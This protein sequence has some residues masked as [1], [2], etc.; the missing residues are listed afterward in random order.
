MFVMIHPET[1]ILF[2]KGIRTFED[3]FMD[4]MTGRRQAAYRN[5]SIPLN[6]YAIPKKSSREGELFLGADDGTAASRLSKWF[7]SPQSVR[8]S[9]K[10]APA[11]GSFF[12]SR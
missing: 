6:L 3:A 2:Y 10:K 7:D 11:R 1:F 8:N 9:K 12:W 4:Q 5:G